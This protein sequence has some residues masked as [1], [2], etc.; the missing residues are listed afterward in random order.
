MVFYRSSIVGDVKEDFLRTQQICTEITLA[1]EE[2]VGAPRRFLR[3][4][5]RGF[6]PLM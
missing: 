3:S 2:E 5:L 4:L 1:D 6:S